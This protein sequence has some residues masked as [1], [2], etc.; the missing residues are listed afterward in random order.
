[1]P[2]HTYVLTEY[3]LRLIIIKL[4]L[5]SD[6]ERQFC[7]EMLPLSVKN[8]KSGFS[9]NFPGNLFLVCTIC[10]L[11]ACNLWRLKAFATVYLFNEIGVIIETLLSN[12]I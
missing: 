6:H 1:M 4:G 10:G 2:H 8:L 12:E 9:S 7:D 3:W 11:Y 5:L